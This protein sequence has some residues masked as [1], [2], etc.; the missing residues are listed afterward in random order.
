MGP[1]V[2]KSDGGL[3]ARAL[4]VYSD[5][6]SGRHVNQLARVEAPERFPAALAG[7]EEAQR[8]GVPVEWRSCRLAEEEDLARI[9]APAYLGHLKKLCES[10]GGRSE[11]RR[12]GKEGRSR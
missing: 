7:V 1:D 6:A 4:H 8:A 2:R 12:V 5:P 11:E 9:H 10:G 3:G